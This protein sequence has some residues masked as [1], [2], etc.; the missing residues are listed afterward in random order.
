[1]AS[2]CALAHPER[3]VAGDTLVAM[4]NALLVVASLLA[5]CRDGVELEVLADSATTR[6]E[7]FVASRPAAPGSALAALTALGPAN[8]DPVPRW[9]RARS[10]HATSPPTARSSPRSPPRSA[11]ITARTSSCGPMAS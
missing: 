7:V 4:R 11:A 9:S 1:M 10:T 3:R 6:V 2:R 5:A 8:P